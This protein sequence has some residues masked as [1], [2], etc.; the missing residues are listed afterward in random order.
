MESVE[1]ERM[2]TDAVLVER[3][4]RA[5]QNTVERTEEGDLGTNRELTTE[6]KLLTTRVSHDVPHV[7]NSDK[8][9]AELAKANQNFDDLRNLS[10]KSSSV[11]I[12]CPICDHRGETVVKQ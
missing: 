4:N 12:M 5:F 11:M 9:P 7:V 1:D 8:L 6:R 2:N 3:P 10:Y